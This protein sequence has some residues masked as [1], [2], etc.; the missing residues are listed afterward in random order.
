MADMMDD[1]LK[2]QFYSERYA[3][4]K[5][6]NNIDVD[7]DGNPAMTFVSN[8]NVLVLATLRKGSLFNAK[9]SLCQSEESLV[10]ESI[11]LLHKEE[12]ESV[13]G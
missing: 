9:F 5:L 12:D 6:I 3:L 8:L 13:I 10:I 4:G 11:E 1:T 7:Q 2:T